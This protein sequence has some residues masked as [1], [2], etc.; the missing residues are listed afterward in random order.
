MSTYI[1]QKALFWFQ[2][3]VNL[4]QFFLW[5]LVACFKVWEMSMFL[6]FQLMKFVTG[7]QIMLFDAIEFCPTD[8]V[9]LLEPAGITALVLP[10][11]CWRQ[12][13]DL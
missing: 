1:Y 2:V 3:N 6:G 4:V 9:R 5:I 11:F 13:H 7:L 12:K 10:I 8:P